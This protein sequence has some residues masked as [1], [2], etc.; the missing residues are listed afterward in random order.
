M[1]L[2]DV[3]LAPTAYHE[4][5][6]EVLVLHHQTTLQVGYTPVIHAGVVVQAARV[7]AMASLEDGRPLVSLR[8]GDRALITCRFLYGPEYIHTG[9]TLLFREGRAKGVGRVTAVACPKDPLKD[10]AL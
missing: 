2:V 3:S 1:S 8:T 6:A 9:A 5:S 10:A 7:T 4:F